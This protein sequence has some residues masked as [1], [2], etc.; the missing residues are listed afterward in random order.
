MFAKILLAYDG[1][2]SAGH[3]LDLARD[4][5][6]KYG[7]VLRVIAVARPPE[8]GQEVETEAVLE[9]SLRHYQGMLQPLKETLR[10]CGLAAEFDVIIGHP[11]ERIVGEAER[12]GAELVVLGHRGHGLMGRWLVGSVAKQVMH[13]AHC[14]VLVTR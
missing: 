4:V 6:S 3:A 9:H 1:S 12:W 14:A 8:F 13:H 2:E 7:A 10:D 11:A 5:A